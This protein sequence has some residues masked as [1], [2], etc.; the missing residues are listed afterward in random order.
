M[1]T[2]GM[3]DFLK[4]IYIGDPSAGLELVTTLHY[5]AE[6]RPVRFISSIPMFNKVHI[7]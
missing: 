4:G 1:V 6:D 7:A 2:T 5:G 3:A